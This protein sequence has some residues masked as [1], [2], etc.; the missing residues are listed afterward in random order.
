MSFVHPHVHTGKGHP[1]FPP[2]TRPHQW[3]LSQP[4]LAPI[5]GSSPLTEYDALSSMPLTSIRL[6]SHLFCTSRPRPTCHHVAQS[7]YLQMEAGRHVGYT[8]NSGGRGTL[9]LLWSCLATIVL[10]TW[11]IQ[12]LQVVPWSTSKTILFR[13]KV[14]WMLITLLCPEYVTWM[15]FLQWQRARRYRE[16]CMLG[17]KDWTMEHGFYVDMGGLQISLEGSCPG[18]QQFGKGDGYILEFDD[19]MRFTI[20]LDDLILLLKADLLPLPN[21]HIRDLKERS[22]ND[23]FATIV[24]SLQVLYFVVQ[25]VGRLGSNLPISTLEVSTLAFVCCA[26]FVEY[27]WWNK[28]L[29]LRT[30]TVTTLAPD[31]HVQFISIM[32]RL[33]FNIPEQDLAE[34]N[35]FQQLFERV[36][37]DET[38]RRTLHAVLVGCLFNGIYIFAWNFSFASETERL[39]W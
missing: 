3:E 26:A 37:G 17:Y 5:S 18:L 33:H 13:K 34:I 4:L 36:L 15:A 31:K 27:F 7:A 23:Q 6:P 16:V 32:P 22:K 28:P 21:I 10:C 12:R 30:T 2:Q 24:T 14:F 20:R 9:D 1:S 8:I 25:S 38:R 39:L 29:D 35:G 11:T 19:S